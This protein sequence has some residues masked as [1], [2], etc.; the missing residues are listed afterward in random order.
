MAQIYGELIR[1][2]LHNAAADLTP[3]ATGLLYFNTTTGLKWY[4]GAAWRTAATLAT[5]QT[6]TNKT[7]TSPVIGTDAQFSNQ[8]VAK[9]YEGVGGGT[10]FIGISAPAT[11][12]ADKTFLL[13]DGDGTAGQVLKTNG[14][15]QLGWA[16]ALT[17]PLTTTGDIIYSSDNSGTPARLAGAAGVLHGAA[18][19]APSWST[20]VDADV[21]ASAAIAGSK[22]VAATGSVSG[23]VTTSSQVLGGAKDFASVGNRMK[24]YTDGTNQAAGYIGEFAASKFGASAASSGQ[25]NS[26]WWI[27]TS[28]TLSPGRWWIWATLQN[29]TVASQTVV[30]MSLTATPNAAGDTVGYNN[31]ASTALGNTTCLAMGPVDISTSG[32][33]T[34][35]LNG[36]QT[37]G[38]MATAQWKGTLYAL[39]IG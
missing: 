24:G 34:F 37:G 18:S 15:L 2:Q 5:V 8:A 7:L 31:I 4:D 33:P 13:P 23:V 14:A 35:Y 20:I 16:S 36:F 3:V 27:L 17:S 25:A 9:F 29:T 38:T 1:A 12:T 30:A 6:L 39:R 22:I 19:G 32:S 21:N 10:N 11:V 26:T 28:I